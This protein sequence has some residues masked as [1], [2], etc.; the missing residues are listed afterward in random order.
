MKCAMT[1]TPSQTMAAHPPVGL[2]KITFVILFRSVVG[3]SAVMVCE[4]AV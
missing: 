1:E 4:L 2:K 3:P